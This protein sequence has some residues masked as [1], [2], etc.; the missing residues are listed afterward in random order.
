[1]DRKQQDIIL[2]KNKLLNDIREKEDAYLKEEEE[3]EEYWENQIKEKEKIL[4]RAEDN[5]K[6]KKM[7]LLNTRMT[8]EKPDFIAIEDEVREQ[9]YQDFLYDAKVI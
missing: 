9:K 8:V 6:A 1:M 3:E 7:E 4:F 2:T 5:I